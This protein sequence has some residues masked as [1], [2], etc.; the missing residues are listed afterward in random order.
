M[1]RWRTALTL[2]VAAGLCVAAS[3]QQPEATREPTAAELMDDLMWGRGTVGGPFALTDHTGARRTDLDFRGRVLLVYFGYMHCPDVC[4]T[5]LL[6]VAQAIDDLG[7]AGSEV[8]PLFISVDPERDTPERLAQYVA[9]FH[10]RLI[11]L[12]GSAEEIRRAA[13]AYKVWYA[14]A[15]N[16]RVTTYEMEHT[17]Y[18]Y[19]VDRDG[20]YA[21]FLPPG[22]SPERMKRAIGT[23][24]PGRR[25]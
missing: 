13:R 5:D 1:R 7:P 16:P 23:L 3:A 18:V 8:Q 12:T 9:S 10:P 6:A 20:N 14:K 15:D 19:L 11:G 21:G 17:S 25:K 4:P 2:C 22:T 24:L